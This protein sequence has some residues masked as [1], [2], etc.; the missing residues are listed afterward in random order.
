M[1]EQAVISNP[2][3]NTPFAEPQRHFFFGEEG[4]TSRII[5][6]RR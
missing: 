4:I 5:E 6:S 1:T 3:I 2:I